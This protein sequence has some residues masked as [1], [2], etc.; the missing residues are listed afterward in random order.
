MSAELKALW[1]IALL[2]ACS[3]TYLFI[4]HENRIAEQEDFAASYTT[5][6]VCDFAAEKLRG[7]QSKNDFKA[8]TENQKEFIKK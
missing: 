7:Y 3:N 8:E 6:P 5:N 2:L 4:N 1:L